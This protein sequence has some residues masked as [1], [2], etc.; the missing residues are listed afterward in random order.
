M[1]KKDQDAFLQSIKG[2]APINKKNRVLKSPPLQQQKQSVPKK[3]QE[4]KKKFENTEIIKKNEIYLPINKTPINKKLKKGKISIDRKIDFHGMSVF[5][6]E[7][8]F[9]SNIVSCYNSNLRCILFITGKGV[10]KKKN[11]EDLGTRLYY[12]KIRTS[13][14]SW[15]EKKELNKYILSVEVAPIEQGADGAFFI[16]LRKKTKF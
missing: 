15:V 13:F 6:A 8:V 4:L 14:M 11:Q 12:G 16:Y 1:I 9:C 7:E 2:A 10:W 5:E 3:K